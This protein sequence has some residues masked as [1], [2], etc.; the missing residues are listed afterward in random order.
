MKENLLDECYFKLSYRSQNI[1]K[2]I[3]ITIYNVKMK[4][5]EKQEP[6][7]TNYITKSNCSSFYV[8]KR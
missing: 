5:I 2:Q 3:Q 4:A 7:K 6:K 1:F 8:R